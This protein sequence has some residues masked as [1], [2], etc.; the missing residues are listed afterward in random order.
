MAY[1]ASGVNGIASALIS[2]SLQAQKAAGMTEI[3]AGGRHGIASGA[4]HL[5][6]TCGFQIVK[7]DTLYRKPM[8]G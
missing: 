1:H 6:E 8:D 2:K 3:G 4:T 5:Y 7:Q